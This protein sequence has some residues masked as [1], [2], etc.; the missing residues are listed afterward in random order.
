MEIPFQM[1]ERTNFDITIELTPRLKEQMA[2]VR[3]LT[4]DALADATALHQRDPDAFKHQSINW[5][6][7]RVAA[8]DVCIAETGYAFFNILIEEGSPTNC[9]ALKAYLGSA[10]LAAGIEDFQI[11]VEW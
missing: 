9:E 2:H 3:K 1:I 8:V 5:A 10:L 7:L 4:E 11:D 6:S